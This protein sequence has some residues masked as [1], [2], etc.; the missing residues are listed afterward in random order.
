MEIELTLSAGGYVEPLDL[1]IQ[2][3]RSCYEQLD[4]L[5]L[6]PRTID[7]LLA[8]LPGGHAGCY[9][10]D[11]KINGIS[12]YLLERLEIDKVEL[13]SVIAAAQDENEVAR[14]LRSRTN[15]EQ[16]PEINKTLRRIRPAHS[17][18]IAYFKELYAETLRECPQLEYVFDI[19]DADDRRMFAST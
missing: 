11:G 2:P 10:I 15:K 13:M 17:A 6:M 4:G 18:D 19:I 5:M 16:Y 14:W 12:G 8:Q 7:K 1:R 3:P 9:F